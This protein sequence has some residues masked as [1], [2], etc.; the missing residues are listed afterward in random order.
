MNHE[1]G[2]FH[3]KSL[4]ISMWELSSERQEVRLSSGCLSYISV[5]AHPYLWLQDSLKQ[6]PNADWKWN[7]IW[8]TGKENMNIIRSLKFEYN[9]V[10]TAV[11]VVIVLLQ[12]D[13]DQTSR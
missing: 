11:C 2:K 5:T 1:F 10:E 12:A 7:K 4:N 3:I 8:R 13:N 6:Q 9:Y